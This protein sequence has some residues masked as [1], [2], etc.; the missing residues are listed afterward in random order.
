[1]FRTTEFLSSRLRVG[2]ETVVFVPDSGHLL[3]RIRFP[4][5]SYLEFIIVSRSET[6]IDSLDRLLET[7]DPCLQDEL[8][9]SQGNEAK[10]CRSSR[11]I[12]MCASFS[13]AQATSRKNSSDSTSKHSSILE[14]QLF[15]YR[16]RVQQYY[17]CS[18]SSTT[19][20]IQ[21]SCWTTNVAYECI[22]CRI[23]KKSNM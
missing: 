21:D 20:H 12:F 9:Q 4:R 6:S 16:P 19:M 17:I 10:F 13:I 18:T 15:S 22:T 5:N 3:Q 1:M 23:L 2:Q 8:L 7:L 11:W 14:E